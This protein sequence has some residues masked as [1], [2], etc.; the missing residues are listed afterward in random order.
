[1]YE[2]KVL[3]FFIRVHILHHS[4]VDNGIYG[5][6]MIKELESH[7]YKISPG[8]LYPIL[9]DLEKNKL[10]IVKEKNVDGKIRKIYHPTKKG[11]ETLKKLKKFI[12]ELSNEVIN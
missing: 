11:K 6:E 1:M 8:T 7:G 12:I 2:R 4:V 10:L 3:L 5:L 9:H